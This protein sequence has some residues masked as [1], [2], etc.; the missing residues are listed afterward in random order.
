MRG[1]LWVFQ[2]RDKCP[3]HT[4]HLHRDA[5]PSTTAEQQFRD[6]TDGLDDVVLVPLSLPEK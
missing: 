4:Q 2:L 1:C 6:R 3:C 5:D